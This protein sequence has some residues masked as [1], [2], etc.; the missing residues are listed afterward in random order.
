MLFIVVSLFIFGFDKCKMPPEL[1]GL[2][3]DFAQQK[4]LRV[5]SDHVR[6][7]CAW[8]CRDAAIRN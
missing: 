6:R 5:L 4:Q 8:I 7:E 2:G 3:Y 1:G